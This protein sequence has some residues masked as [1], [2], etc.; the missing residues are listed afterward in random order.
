L[1]FFRK[2]EL[3][4]TVATLEMCEVEGKDVVSKRIA[5]SWFERFKHGD[6]SLVDKSRSGRH[7]VMNDEAL[8]A[9]VEMDLYS[10]YRKLSVTLGPSKDFMNPY[11]HHHFLHWKQ[12]ETFGEVKIMC[13]EFFNSKVVPLPNSFDC[14]KMDKMMDLT[15]LNNFCMLLFLNML[16]KAC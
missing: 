1:R 14:R 16:N 5:R 9:A 7:S 13:L 3:T 11:F 10:S 4:A 15:L 2:K 8:Q 12:F 6:T